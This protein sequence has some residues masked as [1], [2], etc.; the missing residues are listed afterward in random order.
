[1][2]FLLIS[3]LLFFASNLGAQGVLVAWQLGQ[4][5]AVIE[6]VATDVL[7]ALQ[8]KGEHLPSLRDADYQLVLYQVEDRQQRLSLMRELRGNNKVKFVELDAEVFTPSLEAPSHF[9]QLNLL[10][11]TGRPIQYACENFPIA[12]IDTGVNT[13]HSSLSQLNLFDTKKNYINNHLDKSAE[14]DDGHGTHIAGLIAAFPTQYTSGFLQKSWVAGICATATLHNMKALPKKASGSLSNV[15][16]ALLDAANGGLER[17]PIINASLET[18]NSRSLRDV[19][20]RLSEQGQF[21]IAAAGNDGYLMDN[22]PRYPAAYSNSFE[23]VISVA[24]ADAS[25]K[26]AVSSNYGYQLVDFAAPGE[27]L[28]STWLNDSKGNGLFQYA[29]GTSMATPLV[30]ATLAALMQKYQNFNLPPAAFRAALINSLTLQSSLEGKLR[31]SGVL[32]TGTALEAS[33]NDLFKP[34][35][36]NFE[37]VDNS[38][39]IYLKGYLLNQV[40]RIDFINPTTSLKQVLSFSYDA[41]KKGLLINLPKEWREGYLQLTASTQ[42]LANLDFALMTN[43]TLPSETLVCDKDYCSVVWN[44]YQ[45]DVIRQDGNKD[46][47][48]WLATRLEAGKEVLVITGTDLSAEWQFSF[49][50]QSHL[51]LIALQADKQGTGMQTLTAADGYQLNSNTNSAS[52]YLD[53][54][55]KWSVI[56]SPLQQI[57]LLP[58][59]EIKSSAAES[60]HCYIA[61]AVYGD[62]YAPEVMVLREFRDNY[63]MKSFLGRKFVSFYYAYSPDFVAWMADKPRLQSLIRWWLNWFISFA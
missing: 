2:R 40:E 17:F 45:L 63:L 54:P 3:C 10:D 4:V 30:A 36:F 18:T 57:V 5:P 7:P 58:K 31:Y 60:D 25:N 56:Q 35:W 22:N 14:D 34:T 55:Q 12:V 16:A 13:K 19:I 37:W 52:W 59:V 33:A 46:A 49:S 15:Y 9:R 53:Q 21:V 23:T 50:G 43:K 42:N 1:M 44:S 26:L 24:N 32:N 39:A 11:T 20:E 47:R 8:I 27:K 48:W 61:T 38:D 29:S 28:L 51:K 41:E 62:Y 6:L